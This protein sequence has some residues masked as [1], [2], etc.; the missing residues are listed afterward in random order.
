MKTAAR[1]WAT[2][3]SEAGGREKDVTRKDDLI[4]LA[5]W[6]MI[7]RIRYGYRQHVDARF[8]YYKLSCCFHS[9]RDFTSFIII[10]FTE[11]VLLRAQCSCCLL[12]L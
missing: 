2:G 8:P 4:S 9:K 11:A 10:T 12:L 3:K 5:N 6:S 1:T 7:A